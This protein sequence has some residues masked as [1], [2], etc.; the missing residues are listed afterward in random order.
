MISDWTVTRQK[1]KSISEVTQCQN[2]LLNILIILNALP[3]LITYSNRHHQSKTMGGSIAGYRHGLITKL[4]AMHRL[5]SLAWPL[6]T[7]INLLTGNCRL[8]WLLLWWN[9]GKSSIIYSHQLLFGKVKFVG[10]SYLPKSTTWVTC[11]NFRKL[12]FWGSHYYRLSPMIRPIFG[13]DV[14][15]AVFHDTPS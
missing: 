6:N 14:D 7:T 1:T 10:T 5:H 8:I 11:N 12:T 4:P 2:K 15:D 13:A 9:G 3:T